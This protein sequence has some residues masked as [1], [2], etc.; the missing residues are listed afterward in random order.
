MDEAAFL[1]MRVVLAHVDTQV[2][3]SG[4][5]RWIR[6]INN[7][8]SPTLISVESLR[9]DT[10]FRYSLIVTLVIVGCEF[11]ERETN[12]GISLRDSI[13]ECERRI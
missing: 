13:I 3:T 1:H 12:L 11:S 7:P 4:R 2:N 8:F 6:V 5:A 10:L 9:F